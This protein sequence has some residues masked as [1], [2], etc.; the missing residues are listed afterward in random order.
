MKTALEMLT[1]LKAA[2]EA[3]AAFYKGNPTNQYGK[4]LDHAHAVNQARR[5]LV[6]TYGSE[7]DKEAERQRPKIL[8]AAIRARR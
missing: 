1:D 4:A 5:V 3:N 8:A 6:E 2:E 7:E